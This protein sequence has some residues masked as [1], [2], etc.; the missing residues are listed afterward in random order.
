MSA[1]LKTVMSALLLEN[2]EGDLMSSLNFQSYPG[3]SCFY[4]KPLPFCA[5]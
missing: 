2:F 5:D 4:A 3:Y 1:F